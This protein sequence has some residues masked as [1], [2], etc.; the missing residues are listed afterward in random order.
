M[1]SGEVKILTQNVF[2]PLLGCS[3]KK[4]RLEDFSSH[5]SQYD[6]LILQEVMLK[7]LYVASHKTL[8]MT[9]VADRF[10]LFQS[11]EWSCHIPD[12]KNGSDTD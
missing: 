6:V 4:E 3:H 12:L 9:F 2:T 5:A 10:L 7:L 1:A 8:N 11:L